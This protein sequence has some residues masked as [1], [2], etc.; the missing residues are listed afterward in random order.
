MRGQADGACR[1]D[2]LCSSAKSRAGKNLSGKGDAFLAVA[3]PSPLT[4]PNPL[5]KLRSCCALHRFIN[6]KVGL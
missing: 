4:T 3:T 1:K 5:K 6:D 2:G